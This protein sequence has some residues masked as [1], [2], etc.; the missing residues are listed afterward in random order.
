MEAAGDDV[1]GVVELVRLRILPPPPSP[2]APIHPRS[3]RN[4]VTGAVQ[5]AALTSLQHDHRFSDT[6]SLSTAP[7]PGG[8]SARVSGRDGAPVGY[9]GARLRAVL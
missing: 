3:A 7:F 4:I 6:F 9:A 5:C 1:P 8:S 2:T